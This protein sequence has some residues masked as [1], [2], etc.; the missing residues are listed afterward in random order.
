MIIVQSIWL[1]QPTHKLCMKVV[2]PSKKLFVEE[3]L[4]AISRKNFGYIC[5]TYIGR[6]YFWSM[7]VYKRTWN[8]CC[9]CQF[10]WSNR[11]PKHVM[12]VYLFV[13][14]LPN[15]D[16]SLTYFLSHNCFSYMWRMKGILQTY[17]IALNFMNLSHK[18]LPCCSHFT[19]LIMGMHYPRSPSMLV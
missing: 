17:A 4:L 18:Y 7:D 11:E 14:W 10:L 5:A 15:C 13:A 19:S 3:V 8:V 12:F 2:F 9:H 6:M 16:Y 1:H